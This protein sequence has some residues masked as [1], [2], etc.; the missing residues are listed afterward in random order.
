MRPRTLHEAREVISEFPCELL[1]ETHFAY[2]SSA[3]CLKLNERLESPLAILWD[4]SHT[5]EI[6]GESPAE[7]WRELGSLIRHVHYKDSTHDRKLALP[8]CGAY[9]TEELFALLRRENFAGGV[10]LE[11][12]KIWVPELPPLTEALAA[13]QEVLSCAAVV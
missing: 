2:R 5:W 3:R 8:G 11:W 12:E 7:T 4:S 1:M 9:P 10:S 6:G 13:F